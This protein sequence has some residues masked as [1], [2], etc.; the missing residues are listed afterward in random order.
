MF[1]V[2]G[3]GWGMIIGISFLTFFVL[4]AV[5]TVGAGAVLIGTFLV[6]PV[7]GYILARF[8]PI[9]RVE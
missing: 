5:F 9:F 1:G 4:A 6:A 8:T 7:A 2:T 3:I